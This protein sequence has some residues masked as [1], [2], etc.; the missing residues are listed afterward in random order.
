MTL[1]P[2]SLL[3]TIPDLYETEDISDPICHVK[4]FLPSTQWTWYVTE[5]SKEDYNLCFGYVIGL[6]S[7]LGY[8]SLEELEG[9]KS[10]LGI[11]VERDESFQPTPLSVIK[12]Q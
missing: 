3:H 12:A 7:E 8:F 11:S 10:S 9:L 6:E 4:L 5:L 1:I 2:Q